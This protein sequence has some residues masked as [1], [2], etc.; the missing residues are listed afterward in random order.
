MPQVSLNFSAAS[1]AMATDGPRPR[2]NSELSVVERAGE[3]PSSR[4][5]SPCAKCSGSSPSAASNAVVAGPVRQQREPGDGR[6]DEGL[7]RGDALFRAGG[8]CRSRG[9]DAAP[10]ASPAVLVMAMVSAPP[11]LRRLGHGDDVR[12]LARLRDGEAGRALQLAAWRRRSRRSTGRARRPGCRRSARSHISGRRRHGRTS[13]ARPWSGS[14]DRRLAELAR[15]PRRAPPSEASSRRAAASGISSISRRIWVVSVTVRAPSLPLS[16]EPQLGDEIIGVAPIDRAG[17]FDD[18]AAGEVGD[19][20]DVE[21]RPSR[22]A[23]RA[24]RASASPRLAAE[25]RCTARTG[26]LPVFSSAA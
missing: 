24:A 5:R 6:V 13:R 1:L 25:M 10:A 19:A 26:R 8:R 22:P 9:R 15:R 21:A 11:A 23:R 12:A 16:A 2:M 3:L 7:G 4:R 14:A 17:E 18:L 20:L